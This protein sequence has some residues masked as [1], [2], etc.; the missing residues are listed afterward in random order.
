MFDVEFKKTKRPHLYLRNG[1]FYSSINTPLLGVDS[2]KT[3]ISVYK[4]FYQI[5]SKRSKYYFYFHLYSSI[6]SIIEIC[7][8][9]EGLNPI[10]ISMKP[11]FLPI[12]T[13]SHP[14]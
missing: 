6:F 13:H 1:V 14:S 7:G 9:Q 5:S 4:N 11:S 8:L 12:S 3:S 2:R 10:D